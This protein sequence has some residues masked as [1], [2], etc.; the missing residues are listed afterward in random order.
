MTVAHAGHW[1][2]NSLV[3]VGP[4]LAVFAWLGLSAWR[5]RRRPGRKEP[6]G[7]E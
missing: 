2:V 7:H 3:V 1:A 5:Q 6:A 4:L